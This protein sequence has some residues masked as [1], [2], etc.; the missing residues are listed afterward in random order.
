M[1]EVGHDDIEVDEAGRGNVEVELPKAKR[2]SWY[3]Y[4]PF[5]HGFWSDPI[6]RRGLARYH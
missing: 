2:V 6:R 3:Y 4:A 1:N 5:A